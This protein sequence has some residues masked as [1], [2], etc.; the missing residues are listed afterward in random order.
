MIHPG[1]FPYQN[2]KTFELSPN[3]TIEKNVKF[4]DIIELR[5]KKIIRLDAHDWQD[6]EKA[7]SG[8][9]ALAF[10]E[11]L[12]SLLDEGGKD[13]YQYVSSKIFRPLDSDYTRKLISKVISFPKSFISNG[14]PDI[15]YN[16]AKVFVFSAFYNDKPLQSL[17]NK[18]PIL[19][20]TIEVPITD[21]A[22][23]LYVFDSNDTKIFKGKKIRYI[24]WYFPNTIGLSYSPKGA[25]IYPL[26]Q[27]IYLNMV[28][29]TGK[30]VISQYP[31]CAL[32]S[33]YQKMTDRITLDD[34]SFDWEKSNIQFSPS[35]VQ[36]IGKSILLN[37]FYTD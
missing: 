19:S 29:E 1:N 23:T 28:D 11:T 22:K 14:R 32:Q 25:T 26:G 20:R 31:V 21:Q 33:K 8:K 12:I 15:Y 16:P 36:D 7:P 27:G 37:I 24:D 4:P 30:T 6:I 17:Q 18:K 3:N 13:I 10:N 5:N 2:I 35:Q 9:T 34:L